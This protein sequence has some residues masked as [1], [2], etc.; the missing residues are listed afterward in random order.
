[1]AD[2]AY[3]ESCDLLSGPTLREA[4]VV[5]PA[6]A[7]DPRA[8]GRGRRPASGPLAVPALRPEADERRRARPLAQP[9]GSRRGSRRRAGSPASGC[10]PGSSTPGWSRRCCCAAASPAVPRPPR[11]VRY[12]AIRGARPADRLPRPGRPARGLGRPPLPVLLR[13]ERLALDV[14]RR[15]RPRGR[16]GAVLRRPRG[17]RRRRRAARPGSAPRPTTRRATTSAGA[18]TT[19]AWRRSDGHPVVYPGAGSHATYLERGEYI[20]RLPFPGER[21][22]RGPLDLL[23]QFWRDTLDQ[24]DPGDLAARSRAR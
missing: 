5:V 1:M 3:V 11:S 2:R 15:Q 24:P 21:N 14:R 17:A 13:D 10:R 9:A 12:D 23:R 7:L 19:R 16:L 18:G 6:G 8:A 22:L 20:M 4:T